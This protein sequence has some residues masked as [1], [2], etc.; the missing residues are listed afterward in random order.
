MYLGKVVLEMGWGE[1]IGEEGLSL[2]PLVVLK[3]GVLKFR[4]KDIKYWEFLVI[5]VSI[6]VFTKTTNWEARTGFVQDNG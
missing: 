4:R 1:D 3:L 6:V 2:K 5:L